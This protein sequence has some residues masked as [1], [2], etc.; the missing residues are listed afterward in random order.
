M[1]FNGFNSG[2]TIQNVVHPAKKNAITS[3]P[4]T[5]QPGLRIQH[6]PDSIV[7]ESPRTKSPTTTNPDDR[8]RISSKKGE[9]IVYL[10]T[11][12][13]V[14]PQARRGPSS[15]S[16]S[17]PVPVVSGGRRL[18]EGFAWPKRS[19]LDMRLTAHRIMHAH[20]LRERDIPCCIRRHLTATGRF[21]LHGRAGA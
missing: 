11:L 12:D 16:R 1:Y 19:P 4:A 20:L 10:R 3:V 5:G 9:R 15:P 18:S 7:D 17:R 13:H 21:P 14:R 2:T 8:P 6:L